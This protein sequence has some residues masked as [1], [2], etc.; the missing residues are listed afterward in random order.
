MLLSKFMRKKRDEP[1]RR[2]CWLEHVT[3]WN[4]RGSLCINRHKRLYSEVYT[5]KELEVKYSIAYE[6]MKTKGLKPS[7]VDLEIRLIEDGKLVVISRRN[8]NQMRK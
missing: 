1:L 8:L 2:V 4:G 3:V 7:S 5:W 6:K